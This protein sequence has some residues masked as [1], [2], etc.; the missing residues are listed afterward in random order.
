MSFTF[1]VI[2]R[3]PPMA[4]FIIAALM[5][6][7]GSTTDAQELIDWGQTFLTWGII[8]QILWLTI[9]YRG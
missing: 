3:N 6:I 5:I 7:T 2:A 4:L 1:K 9:R 8:L